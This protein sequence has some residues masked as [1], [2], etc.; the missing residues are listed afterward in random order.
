MLNNIIENVEIPEVI[1]N[2]QIS[3]YVKYLDYKKNWIDNNK[4]KINN[5]AKIHYLKKL[6]DLGEEYRDKINKKNKETR[7][8]KREKL[9]IDNP[10]IIIKKGR[11]KKIVTEIVQKKANGRPRKFNL[12]GT[13]I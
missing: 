5:Y 12:D 1:E 8:R 3:R 11:P 10:E 7:L 6:N 2:K 4:D 13:I 9:L